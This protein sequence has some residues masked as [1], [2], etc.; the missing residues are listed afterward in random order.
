MI[1]LAI[2]AIMEAAQ[3]DEVT[4]SL[5]T[6]YI[7]YE[8]YM[9]S[10]GSPGHANEF[11]IQKHGGKSILEQLESKM[12]DPDVWSWDEGE[13]ILEEMPYGRCT[14]VGHNLGVIVDGNYVG[15]LYSDKYGYVAR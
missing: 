10:C 14:E 1:A 15:E 6:D 8:N 3:E 5:G 7:E 4:I 11:K 13:E 9:E 2:K 12:S